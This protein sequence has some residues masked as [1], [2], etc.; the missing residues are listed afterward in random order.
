MRK[1]HKEVVQR[2]N[3][4]ATAATHL[5]SLGQLISLVLRRL[6]VSA[7]TRSTSAK[8][9]A[10]TGEN[11]T[12]LRREHNATRC[13]RS[14]MNKLGRLSHNVPL[15]FTLNARRSS[16]ELHHRTGRKAS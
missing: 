10:T 7:T 14:C 15:Q 3:E 16:H 9:A 13:T 4:A 1:C 5:A 6:V 12:N 8:V 2:S 11:G